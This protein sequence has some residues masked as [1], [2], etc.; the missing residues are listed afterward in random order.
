MV[1]SAGYP[2][3]LENYGNERYFFSRQLK[4]FAV[5]FALFV[6][7]AYIPHQFYKNFSPLFVVASHALSHGINSQ[8]W[9]RK[10]LLSKMGEN[11]FFYVSTVRSGEAWY[12]SVFCRYVCKEIEVYY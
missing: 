9:S 7:L 8:Y 1:Y 10:K 11:R 5:G 12:D 2:L 4:S 3:A 6:V